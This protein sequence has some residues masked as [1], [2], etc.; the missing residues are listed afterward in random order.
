MSERYGYR[1]LLESEIRSEIPPELLDRCAAVLSFAARRL[2]I[3]E[4]RIVWIARMDLE[5]IEREVGPVQQYYKEVAHP[6]YSRIQRDL[7]AMSTGD[8]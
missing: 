4:P 6:R 3:P 7:K 1:K 8:I 2:P 5:T